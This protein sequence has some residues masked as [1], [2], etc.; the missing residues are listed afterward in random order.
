MRTVFSINHPSQY[1]MFKHLAK[2]LLKDGN[3][4]FF[5]IVTFRAKRLCKKGLHLVLSTMAG[6]DT[7]MVTEAILA[8]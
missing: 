5:F 8:L 3:K 4:V 1:H 6:A 2:K 7:L